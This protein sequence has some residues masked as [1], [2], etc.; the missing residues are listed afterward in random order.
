VV[1]TNEA[2]RTF[3]DGHRIAVV[4]A[5]D[6]KDS[7][8]KAICRALLDHGYDAIPVHPDGGEVDG[9]PCYPSLADVPEPLDGVIVM[10]PPGAAVHVVEDAATLGIAQVWL[11]KGIGGKGSVSPDV[12]ETCAAHGID[13]I[14]GACP[15]MFLQPVAAMH[16]VH[17]GVRR[18][19]GAVARP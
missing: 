5:S 19:K 7:F 2:V 10:V 12:L 3:L 18:L 17:R 16:R 11:F 15:L 8:G 6:K 14:A 13:P 1:I 4:G 9:R